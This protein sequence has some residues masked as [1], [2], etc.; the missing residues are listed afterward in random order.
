MIKAIGYTRIVD[1]YTFILSDTT[2]YFNKGHGHFLSIRYC[3]INIVCVFVRHAT[4][5]VPAPQQDH[6]AP[7]SGF[8]A[9]YC[10]SLKYEYLL[11]SGREQ[12]EVLQ[13]GSIQE[14]I[15]QACH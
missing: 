1:V 13:V 4:W 5:S 2:R 10:S 8:R 3:H 6:V 12:H 7:Q 11:R 14:G 9:R 15:L